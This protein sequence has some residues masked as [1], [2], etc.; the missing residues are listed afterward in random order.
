M[1][2]L[3]VVLAYLKNFSKLKSIYIWNTIKKKVIPLVYLIKN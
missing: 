1:C 2:L 3:F